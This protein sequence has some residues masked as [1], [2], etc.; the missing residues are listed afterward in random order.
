MVLRL[1]KKG[2]AISF[3]WIF[4]MIAGVLILIFLV[5]FAVQN[6]D[7]FG[8]VTSKVVSEELEILFSGIE[9]IKTK[10]SLNFD[11]NV[12]LRFSCNQG[13][14]VLNVNGKSGNSLKGKIVFA[15]NIVESD[16]FN[17]ATQPWNVPFRVANF[18]YL[19][20]EGYEFS[21]DAPEI[22]LI[23]ELRG[24]GEK[25]VFALDNNA[26]C[27]NSGNLKTIYYTHDED[28]DDYL[29]YVCFEGQRSSPVRFY[30]KA[31]LIG[32]VLSDTSNNFECVKSGIQ[33]R[34]EVVNDIYYKKSQ[35]MIA[36]PV[37]ID[38]CNPQI[39]G[40]SYTDAE[41]STNLNLLDFD[42]VKRFESINNNLVRGGCVGIY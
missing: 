11:K 36:S 1:N 9:T 38:N 40:L 4:S 31:M 33:K 13:K 3:N 21:G 24:N 14:Q 39:N 19:W 32:A 34:L 18:I 6:T 27:A 8:N 28:L 42:N 26:G 16:V 10:T 22:D 35:K 2:I 23:E 25:I 29:G 41:Y 20:D 17:I 37:D 5:Y 12:E 15:P 30:G 7:L